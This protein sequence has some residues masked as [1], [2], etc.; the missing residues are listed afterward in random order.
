LKDKTKDAY[1][2]S[3]KIDQIEKEEE[4]ELITDKKDK[5]VESKTIKK[6]K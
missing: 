6:I 4:E 3:S 5:K 2:A 1:I